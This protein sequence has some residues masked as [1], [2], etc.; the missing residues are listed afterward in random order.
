MKI[1]YQ[2]WCPLLRSPENIS[3]NV[4]E[5]DNVATSKIFGKSS[6]ADGYYPKS[7][8]DLHLLLHKAQPEKVQSVIT[9]CPVTLQCLKQNG[10]GFT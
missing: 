9:N 6:L 8:S 4:G 3:L 2:S 1:R 7:S 10:K 5:C